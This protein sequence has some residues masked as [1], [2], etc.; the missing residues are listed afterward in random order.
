MDPL[1]DR[2]Q[3]LGPAADAAA[4]VALVEKIESLKHQLRLAKA[5]LGN[6]T[7]YDRLP[8]DADAAE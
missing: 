6:L 4:R 1:T 3:G 5:E 7:R 2:K 8:D